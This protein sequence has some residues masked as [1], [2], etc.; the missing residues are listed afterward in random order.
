MCTVC[1]G[2]VRL[3]DSTEIVVASTRGLGLLCEGVRP[4]KA[5]AEGDA[6]IPPEMLPQQI[7]AGKFLLLKFDSTRCQSLP[8]QP[9]RPPRSGVRWTP[10]KLALKVVVLM[11]RAWVRDPG[12]RGGSRVLCESQQSPFAGKEWR[13]GRQRMNK[14]SEVS[15]CLNP[16]LCLS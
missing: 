7:S 10:R 6:G 4:P 11:P 1:T 5:K 13:Q 9:S 14:K 12:H 15:P 3:P 8:L 2:F 16:R